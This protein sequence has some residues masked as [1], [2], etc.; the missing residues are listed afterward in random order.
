MDYIIQN[1]KLYCISDQYLAHHGIKGMKWGVRR[2]Q[3]EDGSL[4]PAGKKRYSDDSID[5]GSEEIAS[6]KAVKPKKEKVSGHRLRLE[7]K[8]MESG[9]SEAE[10]KAAADK[11]IRV[12]KV[13]AVTAGVTVGACAAY[14][15]KNKWTQTRCDQILKAGTT[16]HNLDSQANERLGEHLYVNYRKDDTDYFRGHFALGKMRHNGHVFNYELTAQNDIKIPSINTRK[17]V[18]KE[19]YDKDPEFAKTFREHS[20][21]KL[22]NYSSKEVYDKMWRSFGDK[23]NP[24]FNVAKRKYFEA[25][26]QKGYDAIVDEWDTKP[27]VFRS[28]APLILLDTSSKSFGSR[29]IRELNEK[30]I[31]LA[32]ANSKNWIRKRDLMNSLT[33]F[34]N[35]KFDETEKQLSKYAA[36]SAKNSEYINKVV[37]AINDRDR[38]QPW[39]KGQSEDIG[40]FT[41]REKGATLARAG[42]YMTKNSKLTVDQAIKRAEKVDNAEDVAKFIA[43]NTAFYGGIYAVA[44]TSDNRKVEKYIK[45]HPNTKLTNVEILKKVKGFG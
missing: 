41:R 2:F 16:F 11:R 7:R 44:R 30:D 5:K 32:Q 14:Y 28:E 10:A 36:K 39:F 35:N 17:N 38:N 33:G 26:K 25:L 19:L 13:L 20:G 21:L 12:E 31:L 22:N 40:I 1:G 42:R 29:T 24:E 43:S 27:F 9:M 8:Y 37:D 4:T 6:G 45:E 34:H 23:D 15:A 18:F 3:K